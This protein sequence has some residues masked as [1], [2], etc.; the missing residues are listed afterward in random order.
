MKLKF[1]CFKETT[2]FFPLY[3]II[4]RVIF[5]LKKSETAEAKITLMNYFL[6]ES[7]DIGLVKT[8]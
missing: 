1:Q 5:A 4:K 2:N 7:N 6:S 3:N 8:M